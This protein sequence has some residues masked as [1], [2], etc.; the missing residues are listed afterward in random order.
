MSP[1]DHRKVATLNSKNDKLF[2]ERLSLDSN[3]TARTRMN[4]IDKLYPKLSYNIINVLALNKD[5][6]FGVRHAAILKLNDVKI[7]QGI[8]LDESE[9]LELRRTAVRK[10]KTSDE[11]VSKIAGDTSL[12]L[13]IRELAIKLKLK[14]MA[15]LRK[16]EG[17]ENDNP[18]ARQW[19]TKKIENLI[20]R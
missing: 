15:L 20:R 19:A 4:A 11:T 10:L 3:E 12:D 2:L 9:K 5:E 16:I 18:E 17:N 1:I 13:Q 6:V 8:A 14:D 7:I